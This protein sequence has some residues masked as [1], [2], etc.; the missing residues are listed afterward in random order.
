MLISELATI[1]KLALKCPTC[2]TRLDVT[3]DTPLKTGEVQL[4]L[5]SLEFP[6]FEGESVTIALTPYA[7]ISLVGRLDVFSSGVLE[8]AW[9]TLN[10]PRLALFDL[11]KATTLS[12]RGVEALIGLCSRSTSPDRGVILIAKARKDQFASFLAGP[13]VYT[14]EARAVSSLKSSPRAPT[15]KIPIKVIQNR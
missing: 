2:E 15:A 10:S 4:S 3:V 12:E 9:K 14:S 13:L 7:R 5:R 6:T 1:K 8:R 11:T